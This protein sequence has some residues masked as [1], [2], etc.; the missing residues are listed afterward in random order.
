MALSDT[1]AEAGHP[2]ARLEVAATVH[3]TPQDGGGFAIDRSELT[4]EGDVPGVDQ[5]AVRG[6]GAA[7][8][9]GLPG[10]EPVPRERGDHGGGH[11][12]LIAPGL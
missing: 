9:A 10:V 12:R 11:A 7:G 6:A 8:R 5:A 3:F 4:V 1:L 2:P